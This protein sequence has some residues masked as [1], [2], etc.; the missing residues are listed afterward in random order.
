MRYLYFSRGLTRAYHLEGISTVAH[1]FYDDMCGLYEGCAPV[2]RF[3]LSPSSATLLGLMQ[4]ENLM[5]KEIPQASIFSPTGKNFFRIK[6]KIIQTE[7]Y[8]ACRF[9]CSIL[10]KIL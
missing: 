8:A 7:T 10:N 9:P 6:F 2:V 3:T 5:Q 4:T 1:P